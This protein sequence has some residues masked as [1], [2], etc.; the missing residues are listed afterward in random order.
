MAVLFVLLSVFE[1]P[2]LRS[3][4]L[5]FYA[6]DVGQADSFLF[7]LPDGRNILVDAGTRK[8]GGALVSRL[9]RLGV[10]Q[11]DV[12]VAT[13]PHEDHIGGMAGV[14]R[15]FQVKRFWDSGYSHGS[16]VQ[17]TMLEAIREKQTR[18][19]R[20]K[21]GYKEEFGDVSIEVIAPVNAIRGTNSDANNNS[22][23]LRVVYGNVAFLMTGDME[24]AERRSVKK[25]PRATV[26]KLAHHGSSNGTDERVL[27]DV[28]PDLVILSYG[29]GNSYGHPHREVTELIR[30]FKL[31]SYATADGEIKITTDGKTLKVS[32]QNMP[33]AKGRE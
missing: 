16:E 15:A 6:F 25:F 8:S 29:K 19:E 7:R 14:I 5:S 26:L 31:R 3:G 27:R 24:T 1:L 11:I 33:L 12:A 22:I 10:K 30:K 28:S 32:T 21:A 9:R 23:V 2:A 13:H 4:G 18:F 20:P 17:R